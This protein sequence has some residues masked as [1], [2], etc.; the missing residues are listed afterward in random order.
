MP[1]AEII[2]IG[3]EL[4]LG[5]TLDTN[6]TYL[7]RSLR[8]AGIDLFRK[9]TVGDNKDRIALAIQEALK[10]C[11]IVLTTGGLGPTIDD[12][13]RDAVALATGVKSEFQPELWEQIKSRFQRLGRIPT[14]NNRRQ[15]FIPAGAIAIENPVGTAPIFILE[16]DSR[17]IVALPGVPR[18]MSFLMEQ[19]V[20]PY[21]RQRFDLHM[22]IRSRILHTVGVGE[23]QIDDMIGDLEMLS[24]PS[25]GLA[26]H[27]GQVDV[28]ITV[29][30]KSEQAAAQ[31]IQPLEA[32][33][34]QRLGDSIYGVDDATLVDTAL[35]ILASYNWTL[36]VI[37]AGLGGELIHRLASVN[38]PFLS[39]QVVTELTSLSELLKLTESYR[40]S[41]HAD[42][43]L[44]V[45]ILPGGE[46][47]E[48]HLVVI[49][50][51]KVESFTRRYGG[52][53]EYAPKWAINHSLDL[54][55]RLKND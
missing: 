43:G 27:S 46:A 25:V 7:A 16:R 6:A 10:R 15:A 30:A 38:G 52:P 11:D 40:A 50:P 22:V 19:K 36:I 51:K 53:F 26:A 4:L 41:K 54:I 39:G 20:I 55:R 37:E 35:K 48:I 32:T 5:D 18:E 2:T 1:S 33:L 13:T 47:Q 44:G 17:V 42:I 8:D 28:R 24:N 49:T 14:E 29:K 45:A 9:T 21:L 31:L 12:P 34:R 3:T 23:S